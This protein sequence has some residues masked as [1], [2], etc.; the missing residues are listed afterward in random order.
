MNK[1]LV[2]WSF[3]QETKKNFGDALNIPLLQKMTSA[4]VVH[5]GGPLSIR[6]P[7]SP[8]LVGIGSVLESAKFMERCGGRRVF[9]WGTGSK[10]L[11]KSAKHLSKANF[12]SVRGPL[13]KDLLR[14]KG[15]KNVPDVFGDPALLVP[16]FWGE[17]ELQIQGKL[18]VIPH[19][20]EFEIAVNYLSAFDGGDSHYQVLDV[21][22]PIDDFVKSVAT[23]KG[24][25]SSSLHG[26]ILADAYGIPNTFLSFSDRLGGGRFKFD[27]HHLALWGRKREMFRIRSAA[28][29][30]FA[31]RCLETPPMFDPI[32]IL[33]SF[34]DELR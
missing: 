10:G 34:P 19:Y 11:L 20:K 31:A 17:Y 1:L 33:N 29:I 13:T 2:H 21:R 5:A 18:L 15:I 26:L 3:S 23:A 30:E 14:K 6:S 9:V 16:Y 28:D 24:V 25:L 7:F 4:D 32:S 22:S 8:V 27:D 12:Y